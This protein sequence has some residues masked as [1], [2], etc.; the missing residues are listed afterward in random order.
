M[1]DLILSIDTSSSYL[2]IGI[3]S[4]KSN[5][6]IYNLYKKNI[7]DKLLTKYI[8]LLLNDLDISIHDLSAIA[9]NVGPGSFTGLRVGISFVKA[10]TID[11]NP[12]I[13][14][15]SS[16]ENY[17]YQLRNMNKNINVLLNSHSNFYYFQSFNEKFESINDCKL[18]DINDYDFQT[19]SDYFLVTDKS[20]LETDITL[21]KIEYIMEL[22]RFKYN[23][24]IFTPNDLLI[25]NYV[26][27]FK[28]KG[29][30]K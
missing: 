15:I 5:I 26:Q 16:T 18:I 12:K 2:G 22:S 4:D 23:N 7:H 21:N 20:D 28:P 17:A 25:P 3:S 29:K 13:I 24:S 11:E 10:L 9:V 8:S 19:K 1:N 6:L 14:T 27:D 30:S